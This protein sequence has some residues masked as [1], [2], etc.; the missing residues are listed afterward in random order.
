MVHGQSGAFVFVEPAALDSAG[1][2]GYGARDAIARHGPCGWIGEVQSWQRGG[3]DEPGGSCVMS[4]ERP[5][6]RREG[7]SRPTRRE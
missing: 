4:H 6:F 2:L 1:Q 3:A 5:V 7:F